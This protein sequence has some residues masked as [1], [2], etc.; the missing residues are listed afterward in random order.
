MIGISALTYDPDG[1]LLIPGHP[2]SD[3]GSLGRRVSRTQT[4][5]GGVVIQ[6]FGFADGDRELS[7]VIM[8]DSKLVGQVSRLLRLYD[9][10]LVC[11]EDGA[12]EAALES[13]RQSV[14]SC[15]VRILIKARVSE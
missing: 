13:V 2:D 12:Y 4:M 6:D 7:I 11:L 3:L 10:V 8:R 5:D 1:A 14:D 15:I 9:L